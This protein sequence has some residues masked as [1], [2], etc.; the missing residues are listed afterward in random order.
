MADEQ[1]ESSDKRTSDRIC[2]SLMG[3][4]RWG[5]NPW[6]RVLLEDL[7]AGGFRAEW[8]PMCPVGTPLSVKI[9]GLAPLRAT[10]R[11]KN[12]DYIGCEFDNPLYQPL[13]DHIARVS[14]R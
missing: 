7:S 4:L 12:N 6:G 2:L 14:S 13:V 9:A 10:L 11:W 3:E 8:R 5:S 1:S